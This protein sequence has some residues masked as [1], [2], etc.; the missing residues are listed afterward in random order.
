MG[1]IYAKRT[2]GYSYGVP[3]MSKNIMCK[4]RQKVEVGVGGGGEGGS[5]CVYLK[6]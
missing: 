4:S 3:S 5:K 6:F 1:L 2:L